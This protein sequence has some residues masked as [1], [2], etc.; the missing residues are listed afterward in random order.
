[1]IRFV[2]CGIKGCHSV[3]YGDILNQH[4]EILI[5][6]IGSFGAYEKT[7]RKSQD[8]NQENKYQKIK[9]IFSSCKFLFSQYDRLLVCRLKE[10]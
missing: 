8:K 3:C 1:M 5:N 10:V 7:M 2:D 9:V 6:L 4:S